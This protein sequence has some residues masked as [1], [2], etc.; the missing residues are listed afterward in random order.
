MHGKTIKIFLVDGTPTGIR[1]AELMNWTGKAVVC[2][3]SNLAALS[4]R[5]EAKRTGVYVLTGSDPE[6]VTRDRAYIGE[7]DNVWERILSHDRDPDKDFWSTVALFVSKDENLTKAHVRFLERELIQMARSAG[8][9]TL[10]NAA[11]PDNRP[12][13]EADIHDM[14]EYLDHMQI[15]LPV[16]GF[17]LLQPMLPSDM[18]RTDQVETSTDASPVFQM[19]PVGTHATAR[20]FQGEFV[21]LKGSLARKESV[22]SWTSYRQLREQ[23]VAD[24]RLVDAPDGKNY[25]FQEDVAFNSPSAAAAVVYGGNQNGPLV[26]KETR[27]GKSYRDWK[28]EQLKLAGTDLNSST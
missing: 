18:G 10:T 15:I 22:A 11:I 12:L 17:S 9:V 7:G 1:T 6:K 20:E 24:R 23:L 4:G 8:R 13:P 2:Q 19:S 26:W 16:L 25:V 21:V 14:R 3:R 27:S 28:L 5:P